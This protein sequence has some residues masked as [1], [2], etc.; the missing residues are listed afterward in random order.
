MP[1]VM[2]EALAS[3]VPV[4][5]TDVGDLTH[6]LAELR[7]TRPPRHRAAGAAILRV[8]ADAPA[9]RRTVEQHATSMERPTPL[10]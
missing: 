3:G 7:R 2:L 1:N 9:Y 8:V 5:A 6:M 4:V 10:R